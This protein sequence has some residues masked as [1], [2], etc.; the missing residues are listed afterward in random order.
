MD[1][2]PAS[3]IALMGWDNRRHPS[4]SPVLGE[5][6]FRLKHLTGERDPRYNLHPGLWRLE[7]LAQCCEITLELA[8]PQAS[9]WQFE[10]ASARSE[11]AALAESH[12][13]CYQICARAMA[14][15]RTSFAADWFAAAERFVYM[16]LMGLLPLIPNKD[17][18]ARAF[19]FFAFDRVFCN[20]PY[21]MIFSGVLA[22]GKINPHF[23]HLVAG[24]PGGGPLLERI[25]KCSPEQI[26]NP[27]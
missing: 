21:P 13:R 2:L 22:K 20:G 3:Y 6:Q 1:S 24:L 25:S 23:T 9:A 26:R 14:A 19:R 4:P 8:G 15:G 7:T 16:R 27:V 11:S 12:A 5:D 10:R 17:V 18:R